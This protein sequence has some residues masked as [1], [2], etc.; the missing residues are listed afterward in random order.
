MMHEDTI[1]AERKARAE[2]KPNANITNIVECGALTLKA[3]S[4]WCWGNRAPAKACSQLGRTI[5]WALYKG[6]KHDQ[7]FSVG[8]FSMVP[9]FK[10][11]TTEARLHAALDAQSVTVV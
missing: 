8:E 1:R 11:P 7:E 2:D 6:L 4:V 3:F 9:P 5:S 10:W